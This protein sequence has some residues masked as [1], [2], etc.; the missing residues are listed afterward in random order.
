MKITKKQTIAYLR[1]R[2]G[3]DNTFAAQHLVKIYQQQTD[4][5]KNM[6]QS[7]QQNGVGF[8]AYDADFLSSLAKQYIERRSL[9]PTQMALLMKR[10]PKY[11]K[12]ILGMVNQRKLEEMIR[13]QQNEGANTEL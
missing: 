2:L 3:S 13:K 10:M 1:E 9:S 12:Q 5:E 6:E 7:Q 4:D 8:T 11:A